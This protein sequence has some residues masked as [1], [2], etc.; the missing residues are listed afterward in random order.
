MA[1]ASSK[2]VSTPG[3]PNALPTQVATHGTRDAVEEYASALSEAKVESFADDNGFL[4]DYARIAHE[5]FQNVSKSL[6]DGTNSSRLAQTELVL[7]RMESQ[8]WEL[9]REL[10]SHRLSLPN[11]PDQGTRHVLDARFM[12]DLSLVSRL[13]ESD[14][15]LQELLIVKQ[16]LER[17]HDPVVPVEVRNGYW[18]FTRRA[19]ERSDRHKNA[20]GEMLLTELDPDATSRQKRP[21]HVDDQNYENAF[22]ECVFVYLR[23][24]CLEEAIQ[25]CRRCDQSWRA[26]SL[27]GGLFWHNPHLEGDSVLQPAGNI[28]RGLW[29]SACQRLATDERVSVCERAIYGALCGN[30]RALLPMCRSWED[31]VWAHY[32]ALIE[33]S[34]EKHFAAYPREPILGLR[35]LPGMFTTVAPTQ[36]EIFDRAKVYELDDIRY[37]ALHRISVWCK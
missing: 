7:W 4:S 16:W 21:L 33:T 24:G 18:E 34:I 15:A 28:N 14:A 20:A 22:L 11:Q 3:R 32:S 19:L 26:A 10:F 12:S 23:S 30:A 27:R 5:H 36:E 31:V 35:S 17:S 1:P 37:G 13:F 29:K 6:E 2:L 9:V 25:L 8:T